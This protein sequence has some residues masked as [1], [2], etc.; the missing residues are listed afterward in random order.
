VGHKPPCVTQAG[1]E[2]GD[3]GLLGTCHID[4]AGLVLTEICLPFPSLFFV[5]LFAWFLFCFVLFLRWG[6][7]LNLELS[8]WLDS[9]A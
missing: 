4:Q 5:C 1:V 8:D 7:S 6:L 9:L 2:L 3:F